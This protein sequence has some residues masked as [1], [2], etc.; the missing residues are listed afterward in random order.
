MTP[1]ESQQLENLEQNLKNVHGV[2]QGQ[3]AEATK[4]VE[5]LTAEG[6]RTEGALR[7]IQTIKAMVPK[8]VP[9]SILPK[10][11]EKKT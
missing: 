5:A 9:P 11:Q 7:L 10:L 6:Y 4:Q 8:S 3:I 1:E 2:L